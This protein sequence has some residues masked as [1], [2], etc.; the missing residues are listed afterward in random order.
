MARITT[1]DC[2]GKISNHF[3]LT[4][5]AARR[6][7]QLENGNTPLVDDVRNNKPTVTA[8]REI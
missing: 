2:T 5:V 1:E 3:D 8:L 7:R 6:A 4:L